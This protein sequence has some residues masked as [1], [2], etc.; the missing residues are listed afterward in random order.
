LLLGPVVGS[1]PIGLGC[2]PGSR[3]AAGGR[4]HPFARLIPAASPRD[5]RVRLDVLCPRPLAPSESIGLAR[6]LRAGPCITGPT[7]AAAPAWLS[8]VDV[9]S[10]RSGASR[11]VSF[12]FS[13]YRPRRAARCCHAPDD[14]AP[15][16][17]RHRPAP[18]WC[19]PHRWRLRPCGFSPWRSKAVSLDVAD[20]RVWLVAR[21][22]KSRRAR[23]RR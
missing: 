15:A 11:E 6:A 12:P 19:G 4:I 18:L 20:V 17:R 3:A 8:P 13:T 14:P 5:S 7:V 21:R 22:S 10:C 1:S 2:R 16:F 23:L 9:T